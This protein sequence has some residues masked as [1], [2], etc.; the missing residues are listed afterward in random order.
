MAIT[1][2]D[3]QEIVTHWLGCRVNGYLGS[4]YGS[5]V[6][7]LLQTPLA[8]PGADA[9]LA[10]LREDIAVVAQLRPDQLNVYAEA[11]GVDRLDLTFE[12]AGN[13]IRLDDVPPFVR[14]TGTM[15][16]AAEPPPGPPPGDPFEASVV[17]L[18]RFSDALI[19]AKGHAFLA[20]G[21]I[22]Y[23][24]DWLGGRAVSVNGATSGLGG[25][26]VI[27]SAAASL[28]WA[29]Q[30]DVCVEVAGRIKSN[31]TRPR[32]FIR[33]AQGST[34]LLQIGADTGSSSPELRASM[35]ASLGTTAAMGGPAIV[36][37]QPYHLAVQRIGGTTRFYVNGALSASTPSTSYFPPN[38]AAS[39]FVGNNQRSFVDAIDGELAWARITNAARYT[40]PFTPPAEP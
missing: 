39:V 30:G 11:R 23:V 26:N 2:S 31:I 20:D 8:G 37:G 27:Y 12:V 1:A 5:S 9:L 35:I 29:L 10:K 15:G 40:G 13:F 22:T 19:D 21:A 36:Y 17:L 34:D 16:A 28:D 33:I 3:L 18:M 14:P 7:D 32:Q 24:D 25:G 38:T 4:G 6:P